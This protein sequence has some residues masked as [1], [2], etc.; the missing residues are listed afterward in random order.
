MIELDT[1]EGRIIAAAL[2]LAAER[3][4]REVGVRD[5]AEAAG[6]DLAEVRKSFASKA[7]II[8]AF[9][10]RIDDEV[11][12][13]AVVPQSG[14]SKR[15]QLFEVIMSRFDA[16]APYRAALRSIMADQAADLSLMR[17]A[18]ASQAW[19]LEAAGIRADG[20]DG[21]VRVAGLASVYVSVLRTF[22]DDEDPGLA[23]TMA[24]LDRRLRSGERTMGMV[25]GAFDTVRRMKEMVRGFGRRA[26]S[27]GD[28]AP[29]APETPTGV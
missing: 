6:T 23:R 24:V 28:E 12:K 11:L 3:P 22:L 25:D 9:M 27:R 18:L 26:A 5:I 15:D 29:S 2:R 10:R 16:L 13:K 14:Q 20:P 7:D 1:L 19:M 8:V 4:W 21:A 17:P